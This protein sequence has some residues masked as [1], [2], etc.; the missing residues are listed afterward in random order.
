[1]SIITGYQG[2]FLPVVNT[3][4]ANGATESAAIALNG[5]ALV[6]LFIPAAFTGTAISFEAATA[7]DGTYVPVKSTTSGTALSYTVAVSTYCA[8]DP[9]DLLGVN[10]LKIKSGSTEGGAR[11]IVCSLKGL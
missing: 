6:G 8:I 10:F 7:V 3:S 5:M 2:Q 9:K 11:T 1:M 4:I